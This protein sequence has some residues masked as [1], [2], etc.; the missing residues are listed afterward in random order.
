[1]H[2]EEINQW[3]EV[4]SCLKKARN[5]Q[6]YAIPIRIDLSKLTNLQKYNKIKTRAAKLTFH[7]NTLKTC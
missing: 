5:I 6:K 1:M 3:M 2:R 4:K 7:F